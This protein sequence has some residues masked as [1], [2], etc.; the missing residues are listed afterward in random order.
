MEEVLVM[1]S[2]L[3]VGQGKTGSNQSDDELDELNGRRGGV[4]SGGGWRVL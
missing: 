1:K 3:G 2:I 4:V